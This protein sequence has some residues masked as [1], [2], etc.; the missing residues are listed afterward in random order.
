MIDELISL[1]ADELLKMKFPPPDHLLAPWFISGESA[2]VYS[3]PGVGKSLFAMSTALAVASGGEFLGWKA[4]EARKVLLI[5]GEMALSTLQ[6]RMNML[7]PGIVPDGDNSWRRRLTIY[8]RMSQK[9]GSEFVNLVCEGWRE[10]IT[11]KVKREG[12]DLII[13]DNLSVLADVIDEN[14]AGRTHSIVEFFL[15]L[16]MQKIAAMLIHHSTKGGR[17]FRGSSKLATSF[18]TIIALTH[19]GDA[20]PLGCEFKLV[21]TKRRNTSK[22][23]DARSFNTKLIRGKWSYAASINDGLQRMVDMALTKKYPTQAALAD[24]MGYNMNRKKITLDKQKAFKLGMVS[25]AE[26]DQCFEKTS[27]TSSPHRRSRPGVPVVGTA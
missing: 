10:S 8:P 7:A 21:W 19:K 15:D 18:E 13:L 1:T 20:V 11:D 2:M 17:E 25:E 27:G 6:G 3:P 5:D 14:S 4:P 9:T 22:V 26:W 23:E 16:K 12:F 24:A